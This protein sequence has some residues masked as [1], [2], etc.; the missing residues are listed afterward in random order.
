MTPRQLKEAKIEE[1]IMTYKN[2]ARCFHS[3]GKAQAIYKELTIRLGS[4]ALQKINIG[5]SHLKIGEGDA[6]FNEACDNLLIKIN[7]QIL[8]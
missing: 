3:L 7:G 8:K 2:K 6:E 5:L 4:D 1:L